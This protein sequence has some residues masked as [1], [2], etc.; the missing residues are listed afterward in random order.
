MTD[1]R[2][3]A[4]KAA[5]VA[6]KAYDEEF[7]KKID[8]LHVKVARKVKPKKKYKHEPQ[9]DGAIMPRGTVQ[10][11]ADY[12]KKGRA[13]DNFL[14]D[15]I[16]R[17]G[18]AN[19]PSEEIAALTNLSVAEVDKRYKELVKQSNTFSTTDMR[20]MLTQQLRAVM[21]MMH[22][23]A[24]AGSPEHAKIL[25]QAAD[26]LAK[27]HELQVQQTK[28][29]VE[30]VTS[31]QTILIMAMIQAI[32]DRIMGVPEIARA[33]DPEIIDAVVVEVLEEAAGVINVAQDKQLTA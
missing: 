2:A 3:E 10:T 33:V 16:L 7:A 30:L 25:I 15:M 27:I 12:V 17:M 11:L 1:E 6:A 19:V 24:K 4:R 23:A 9:I 22:N 31:E 5:K 32:V 21:N 29:T 26:Q 20:A 28:V 13:T 18:N 14:D 8:N